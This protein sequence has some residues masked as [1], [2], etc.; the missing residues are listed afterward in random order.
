MS[1]F[2]VIL[3]QVG[4]GISMA[5]WATPLNSTKTYPLLCLEEACGL[6]YLLDGVIHAV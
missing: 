3:L 2:L 4:V 5:S 1:F 6:K